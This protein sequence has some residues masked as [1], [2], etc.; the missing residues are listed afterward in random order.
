MC[1]RAGQ[2][3][4]FGCNTIGHLSVGLFDASRTGDDVS[5]REWE[6][7][8]RM[9][10]NTLAYRLPQH[11]TFFQLDADCVPAVLGTLM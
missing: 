6:R 1:V 2:A 9:G 8:R 5:G 10:V 11:K 7:T 4:G 3:G